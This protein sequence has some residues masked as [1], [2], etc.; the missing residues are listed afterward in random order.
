LAKHTV[1]GDWHHNLAARLVKR[2]FGPGLSG[3]FMERQRNRSVRP[4][5]TLDQFH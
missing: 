1:A 4:R 2:T 3:W 5:T